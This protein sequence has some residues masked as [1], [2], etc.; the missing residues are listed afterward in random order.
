MCLGSLARRAGV[1]IAPWHTDAATHR[2][3]VALGRPCTDDERARIAQLVAADDPG[4]VGHDLL[5][6]LAITGMWI[7]Q[8]RFAHLAWIPPAGHRSTLIEGV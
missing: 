4:A 5:R 3:F 2:R 8:E 6:E 1:A 7:E